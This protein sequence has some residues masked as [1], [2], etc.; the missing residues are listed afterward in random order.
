[1]R[2]K[3]SKQY[4]GRHA[5]YSDPSPF[6]NCHIFSDSSLPWS[7]K[8]FMHG[9]KIFIM[10]HSVIQKRSRNNYSAHAGCYSPIQELCFCWPLR[11]DIPCTW[12]YMYYPCRLSSRRD[13][14]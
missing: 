1:M 12:N 9:R 8:Y 4:V 14:L 7:V 11:L 13:D 10:H 5:W 6:A 3:K 2:N